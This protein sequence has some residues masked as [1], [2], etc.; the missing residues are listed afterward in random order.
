LE[1]AGETPVRESSEQLLFWRICEGVL[2]TFK[3]IFLSGQDVVQ[4]AQDLIGT[5][6]FTKVD[7][8]ITG[9]II[10]ETEAYAGPWDKASHAYN[11]RRTKRTEIM[12]QEGGVAYVYLCYGIHSLLNIV[13]N[14]EGIPHAVLLRAIHPTH[15]IDTMIKRRGK[16]HYSAS[17]CSGPGSLTK[18]LGISSKDNGVSFLSSSLWIEQRKEEIKQEDIIALP[19]V[20]IDYAEEHAL[21]PWRF[22]LK[23]VSQEKIEDSLP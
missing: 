3:Q 10:T 15:G 9:G 19:R 20:G 18:A 1:V 8:T 5:S 4:I 11:N 23:V 2:H 7:D 13:T 17:L 21:L 14:K 12:F 16:K 22:C 6:L